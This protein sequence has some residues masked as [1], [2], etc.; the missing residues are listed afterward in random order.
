MT[1]APNWVVVDVETSG[2]D[3]HRDALLEIAGAVVEPTPELR[4]IPESR[5][6]FTMQYTPHMLQKFMANSTPYVQE[7]H[8]RTG[9]WNRIM[10]GYQTTPRNDIDFM[11]ARHLGQFGAAGTMP[12]MGNSVR[13]DMNFMD[14]YLPTVAKYLDYHMRDVSSLAGFA[15]DAF[16]LPWFDKSEFTAIHTAQSDVEAC[17]AEARY[18]LSKLTTLNIIETVATLHKPKTGSNEHGPYII[19]DYDKTAWPCLTQRMLEG[20]TS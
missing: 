18:L 5:F 2:L 3:P 13:L 10:N 6:H 11:L 20:S 12:V 17:I 4:V 19:C 15:H 8:A 1:A 9:L 16:G 7:M 14:V